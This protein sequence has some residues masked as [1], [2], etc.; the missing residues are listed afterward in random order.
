[1]AFLWGRKKVE[2]PPPQEVLSQE[3]I[4]ERMRALRREI[5][6]LENV[7]YGVA[8]FFEG[9]SSLHAGQPAVI[10][11]YQKQFRNVIQMDSDTLKQAKE[12]LETVERDPSQAPLLKQFSIVPCKGHSNPKEMLQRARVLVDVYNRLYP[13][14]PRS[15]E[16]T[17]EETF[18]LMEEAAGAFAA[19]D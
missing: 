11:T 14:R 13:G 4:D 15:Q 18:R 7:I 19:L 16:F 3:E 10:E 1:M 12:L 5:E 17:E 6:E 2:E 9:L 8:L